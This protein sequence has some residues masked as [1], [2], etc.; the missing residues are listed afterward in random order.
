MNIV[1]RIQGIIVKPGEEW[2]K[3]KSES[4]SVGELFKSYI[5]ILA[6]I[7]AVA[8]FIGLCLI[9]KSLPYVGF[10][11]A[12]FT[13][14]FAQAVVSYIFS[15]ATV[16]VL[17]L[18]IKALAPNFSSQADQLSALKLAA[19]SMTPY[20]VAGVLYIIPPLAVI[21]ILAGIYGLYVLYLGFKGGLMGTPSDKVLG[22]FVLSLVVEIVI[23]AVLGWILTAIFSPGVLYRGL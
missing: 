7:P 23:W 18:I 8:Q 5:M 11:R 4:T 10:V 16:Y 2:Q 19:Y 20:F 14:A 6:A 17:A 21:V 3:I 13:T 1:A 15:L 22:Y 9:G 12:S